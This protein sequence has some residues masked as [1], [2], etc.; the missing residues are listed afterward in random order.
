MENGEGNRIGTFTGT[1]VT[2]H[3]NVEGRNISCFIVLF[4]NVLIVRTKRLIGQK[5]L[6]RLPYEKIESVTTDI[7]KEWKGTRMAVGLIALGPIGALLFGKKKKEQ[8]GLLV[9]GQ[10]KDGNKVS[11]PIAFASVKRSSKIRDLIERKIGENKG[12]TI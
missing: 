12:L 2:G 6:F 11:I 9:S 10:D 8:L 7:E 4:D 1:Y 3:P 5:E